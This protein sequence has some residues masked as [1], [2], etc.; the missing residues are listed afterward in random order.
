MCGVLVVYLYHCV[1]EWR[2]GG[3]CKSC[4]LSITLCTVVEQWV[5][6]YCTV[7][8]IGGTPMMICTYHYRMEGLH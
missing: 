8:D 7:F 4:V 2:D 6:C 5:V 3:V 1:Q